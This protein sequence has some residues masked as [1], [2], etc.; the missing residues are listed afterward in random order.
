MLDTRDKTKPTY[1]RV[2]AV[3]QPY[4]KGL[5]KHQHDIIRHF[6]KKYLDE[7]YDEVSL[8]DAKLLI[9]NL[10]EDYLSSLK[11]TKTS[12]MQKAARYKG[13]GQQTDQSVKSSV[14][15]EE[16]VYKGVPKPDLEKQ[17]SKSK[18]YDGINNTLPDKLEF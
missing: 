5:T 17:G 12:G 16:E 18:L 15:S 7:N 11:A 14:M 10:L 3:D 13:V 2:P 8:L 6:R 1:F 9:N 4:A